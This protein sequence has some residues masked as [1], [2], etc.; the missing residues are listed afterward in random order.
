MIVTGEEEIT[1]NIIGTDI[2]I[3]ITGR[4]GKCIGVAFYEGSEPTL[5]IRHLDSKGEFIEKWYTI[6]ACLI[7]DDVPNANEKGGF[8]QQ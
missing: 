3:E 5:Q 2:Q 8:I 4:V 7:P 1:P 6:S